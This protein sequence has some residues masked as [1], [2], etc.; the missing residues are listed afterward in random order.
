MS[1]NSIKKSSDFTAGFPGS[2]DQ[3]QP[4]AVFSAP[5]VLSASQEYTPGKVLVRDGDKVRPTTV[6][7]VLNYGTFAGFGVRDATKPAAYSGGQQ[8]QNGDAVN[9]LVLG[10]IKVVAGGAVV[11]GQA[12]VCQ[13]NGGA[14]TSVSHT[15]SLSAGQFRIPGAVWTQSAGS[16]AVTTIFVNAAVGALSFQPISG[17]W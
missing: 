17:A 8:Y 11:A 10:S 13:V 9:Y 5:V 7:D 4:S 16:G 6:G 1:I 15:G 3:A 2:L 14:L 12:V